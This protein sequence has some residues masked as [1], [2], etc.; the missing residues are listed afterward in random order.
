MRISRA[1]CFTNYSRVRYTISMQPARA[2]P[3]IAHQTRYT[4]AQQE[5]IQATGHCALEKA[6]RFVHQVN[7]PNGTT[8]WVCVKCGSSQISMVA[9]V[10]KAEN[11]S[12]LVSV[13]DYPQVALDWSRCHYCGK[14]FD[15]NIEKL[16]PTRDHIVPRALGGRDALV[17][18]VIACRGCNE[19]KSDR[20]PTCTCT[21]CTTAI[22]IHRRNL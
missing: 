15:R 9:D 8:R 6:R 13:R 20:W 12:P 11:G 10:A 14:E 17:N 21:K 1:D 3:L 16:C 22:E 19:R 5:L 7:Y 4:R 2:G 18:I